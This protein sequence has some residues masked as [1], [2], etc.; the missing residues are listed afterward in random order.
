MIWHGY[1]QLK[2]MNLMRLSVEEQKSIAAGRVLAI[3]FE[4]TCWRSG[5]KYF[6]YVYEIIG[7]NEEG[8]GAEIKCSSLKKAIEL[9]RKLFKTENKLLYGGKVKVL[10]WDFKGVGSREEYFA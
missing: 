5:K 6:E 3:R 4:R 9:D 10:K 7:C 1:S 8:E 2:M